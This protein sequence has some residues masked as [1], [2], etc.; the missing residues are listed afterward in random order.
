MQ[1]RLELERKKAVQKLKDEI[2]AKTQVIKDMERQ[3]QKDKALREKSESSIRM[4]EE[5]KE[6]QK[7]LQTD[8]DIIK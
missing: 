1:E 6:M 3:Q 7:N 5:M 2:S 4:L 8:R